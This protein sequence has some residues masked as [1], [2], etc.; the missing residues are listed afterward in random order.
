MQRFGQRQQQNDGSELVYWIWLRKVNGIGCHT[1]HKLLEVF[2]EP[3]RI[4]EADF[5]ELCKVEGIGKEKAKQILESRS[6]AEAE[7]VL[8][9][10]GRNG[11]G[12]LTMNDCRYPEAAKKIIDMP[13]HLFYKGTLR[14]NS[15]GTAI[16]GA[17][18]CSKE[19]K[20]QSVK[21]AMELAEQGIPVISG[22]AKGIDSYA[23]TACLR[24]G[25]YT[26]A[27]LGNGLDICYPAE[28]KILMQRIAEQGLLLSEYE[29]GIKPN[30]K[31]F[32]AR[33]RIIAAWSN[34]V[35]IVEAGKGSGALITG[36]IARKYG[37]EVKIII[38]FIK[39]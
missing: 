24:A 23:H 20:A 37:R 22:M 7:R 28:H 5:G 18:R 26:V 8:F 16:V 14:S 19:G 4:Y 29:P 38:D 25:G 6:L 3:K 10:C 27:I 9:E 13:T 35:I 32:P 1:A 2:G 31:H 30:A 39:R 11:I 17:R 12:I 36:D 21:Y 33:N 34:R 15:M